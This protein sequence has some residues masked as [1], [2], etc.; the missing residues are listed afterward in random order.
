MK[1]RLN[2][3]LREGAL[4]SGVIINLT[5]NYYTKTLCYAIYN[6]RLQSLINIIS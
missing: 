6:L 2:Y 3:I 5:T 4:V 1:E